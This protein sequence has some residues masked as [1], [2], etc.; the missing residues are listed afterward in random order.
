MKTEKLMSIIDRVVKDKVE[1]TIRITPEEEEITIE[2]WKP[3]EMKCPYQPITCSD[4][5]GWK[6]TWAKWAMDQPTILN[7]DKS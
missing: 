6:I 1:V 4:E 5:D 7:E 3:Y 2:P